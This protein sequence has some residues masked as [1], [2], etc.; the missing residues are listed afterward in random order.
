MNVPVRF[1]DCPGSCHGHD[2][3]W[4]LPTHVETTD[5][6]LRKALDKLITTGEADERMYHQDSTFHAIVELIRYYNR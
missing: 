2:P 6:D 3:D 5:R 4:N 1:W